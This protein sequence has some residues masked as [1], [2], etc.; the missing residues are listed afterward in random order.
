MNW[1]KIVPND[2]QKLPDRL[3]GMML[4]GANEY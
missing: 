2:W 4:W 1:E 3:S